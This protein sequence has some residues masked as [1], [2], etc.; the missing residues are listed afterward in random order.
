MVRARTSN[1]AQFAFLTDDCFLPTQ[2]QLWPPENL[3]NLYILDYLD[4]GLSGQ[5][6]PDDVSPRPPLAVFCG[7]TSASERVAAISFDLS[8]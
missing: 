8:E 4:H 7:W 2:M 1:P 6:A 5:P 3:D